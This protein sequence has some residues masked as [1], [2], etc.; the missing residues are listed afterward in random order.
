MK[1]LFAILMISLTGCASTY[2][3]SECKKVCR[4]S[5]VK[6]FQDDNLTC[7]CYPSEE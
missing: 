5:N 6:K 7:A 2:G 4:N 1:Y 3:L